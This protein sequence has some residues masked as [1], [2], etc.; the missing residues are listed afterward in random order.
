MVYICKQTILINKITM[1]KSK[2][3]NWKR[4]VWLLGRSHGSKEQA[5]ISVIS[6]ASSSQLNIFSLRNM[7]NSS[8]SA[9]VNLYSTTLFYWSGGVGIVIAI[10]KKKKKKRK[11]KQSYKEGTEMEQ[12]HRRRRLMFWHNKLE[13]K[14]LL[15]EKLRFIPLPKMGHKRLS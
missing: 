5:L 3:K 10:S 7:I 2:K 1:M 8:Q 9:G 15:A 12:L 4:Y 13:E 6:E 14:N 11:T